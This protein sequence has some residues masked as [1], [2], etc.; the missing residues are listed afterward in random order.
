M[1]RRF[2]PPWDIEDNG[3]CFIVRSVA[4]FVG[5]RKRPANRDRGA[6][7]TAREGPPGHTGPGA[8]SRPSAR[9]VGGARSG[10][11]A[12]SRKRGARSVARAVRADGYVAESRN[13]FFN[14]YKAGVWKGRI[15]CLAACTKGLLSLLLRFDRRGRQKQ[16]DG[17]RKYLHNGL[18]SLVWHPSRGL[19]AP[20][21]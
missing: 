16:C 8:R 3:A 17:Q 6:T 2:P 4:Q 1:P 9:P 13:H 10:R 18:P 7:S 19:T 11:G 15:V 20:T 14:T 21:I 5:R 12:R